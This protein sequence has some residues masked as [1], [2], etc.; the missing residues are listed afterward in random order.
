MIHRNDI[1]YNPS[2]KYRSIMN[3]LESANIYL[4]KYRENIFQ[5]ENID[6]INHCKATKLS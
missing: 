4:G 5:C 1:T 3:K 6:D 2:D